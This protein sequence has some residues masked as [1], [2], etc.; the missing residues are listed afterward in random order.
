MSARIVAKAWK[1]DAF[2]KALI[3][4]PRKALAGEG[5]DVPAGVRVRVVQNS[6]KVIYL[7][8][9]PAPSAKKRKPTRPPAPTRMGPSFTFF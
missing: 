9:P 3:R 5:V 1:N 7:V 6:P 8:L 2:R 4:N